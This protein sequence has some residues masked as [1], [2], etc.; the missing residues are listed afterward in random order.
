MRRPQAPVSWA[1]GGD[2]QHSPSK[3]HQITKSEVV[4]GDWKSVWRFWPDVTIAIALANEA[5]GD[6]P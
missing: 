4:K 2:E 3:E 1:L 5:E 6:S